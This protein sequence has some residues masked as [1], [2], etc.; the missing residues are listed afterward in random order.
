MGPNKDAAV[1]T[2]SSENPFGAK[3]ARQA[4]AHRAEARSHR[5][6]APGAILIAGPTASGKSGLAIKL[7]RRLGG[8][9]INCDSMQVYRD[10]H[11]LSARPSTTDEREA[12]HLLF[13]YVDAARN[14]SVGLWL[15]DAA[16]AI[17]QAR[18]RG[19]VPILAGGTGLYFKALTQGLSAMPPV[20][21]GVRA[22]IREEA[23]ACTSAELHRALVARD[24]VTAARLRPSDRQ[25]IVR[26]LEIFAA[27]GR[28]LVE[29][30]EGQRPPPVLAPEHCVR[31]FL[32]PARDE[33]RQR[34]ERRFDAMLA[35][36]ALEEVRRLAARRL[37]PSLPAMRAHG[38]PWLLSHLRGEIGLEEAAE[39]AKAD[40]RR[41]ARRQFTWFRHQMPGWSWQ[42]PETAEGHAVEAFGTLSGAT[43]APRGLRQESSE[44]R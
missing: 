26:A 19:L 34:I 22:A 10:L 25:R 33:L 38:V 5:L 15:D 40:T 13:G 32:E 12:P 7:A 31:L 44:Q 11:I 36:G 16:G 9:V 3:A 28:S 14:F 37:D 23:K 4:A 8:V 6:D 29:W 21:E 41:Y 43:P 42:A 24:P 27:T 39:A 1:L 18:A 2:R 20:P 30:Q 35:E 17:A